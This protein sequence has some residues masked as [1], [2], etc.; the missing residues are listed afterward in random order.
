[1]S[2]D[3]DPS[4]IPGGAAGLVTGMDPATQT[5]LEAGGLC[6][7]TTTGARRGQPHRIEIA[8]HH[9]DGEYLIAGKPGFRRDWL[10]NLKAHPQFTLHLRNGSDVTGSATEITDP[11]ERD[12]IL[13]E[14]RTRS[15]RVDPAQ[16]RATHDRWVQTSPLV[17]FTAGT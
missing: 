8:F 9:L 1:M 4:G 17:R 2:G 11:A 14:I 6:E 5:A 7:I 13:F 12:R 10:A 3:G 16:A 15:W